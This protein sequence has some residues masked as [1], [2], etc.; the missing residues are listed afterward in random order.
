MEKGT[1]R[2][3]LTIDKFKKI[4]NKLEELEGKY[5]DLLNKYEE[6]GANSVI[7]EKL[8]NLKLEHLEIEKN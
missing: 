6:K 4:Q 3:K 5:N 8:N 2:E 7:Q 1:E